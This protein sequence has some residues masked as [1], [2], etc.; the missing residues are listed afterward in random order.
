MPSLECAIGYELQRGWRFSV[1]YNLMYWTNVMRAAEQIDSTI[2]PNLFP[3]SVATAA[4]PARPAR[5][6][7]EADY[8][9]HGL[10]IGFEKR[11]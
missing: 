1:A 2:N 9:A 4:D 11:W 6:F 5:L 3:P 7:K 10:S 8:L